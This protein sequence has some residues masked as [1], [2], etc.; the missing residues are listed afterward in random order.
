MPSVTTATHRRVPGRMAC[1]SVPASVR[2]LRDT[3]MGKPPRA[4]PLRFAILPPS[5][6]PLRTPI[7]AKT[8]PHPTCRAS[9]ARM[10]K[11]K[12]EEHTMPLFCR[13]AL[14]ALVLVSAPAIFA[15][16]PAPMTPD[17][18][19]HFTPP[20]TGYDYTIRKVM[21]PM[22]DGVKLFTIIAIPK[23][24]KD[25]PIVLTRTPYNAAA[26][27]QAE[28][29]PHMIDALPL[30]S[31]EFVKA[32]YIHVF[33]DVRGKYGSQGTYVMTPPPTGPLNPHGPNDTTDAWDTIDWLVKNLPESNGRVGMIGSSYEGFTVVMALLHPH[34]A[35]KVAAPESPMI[36]GWM[37]DDWFH[38]GAFREPNLDY[39]G[40]QT[41]DHGS[42][43]GLP[44][45]NY[46]D[47]TNFLEAGS[48]GAFAKYGGIQNLTF[49]RQLHDHPAYDAYWQEQALDKLIAKVPLKVPVLWEQ[50]LWDQ[51]DMWGANHSY[52]A[53]EPQDKNNNMNYLVMGPWFHSQI[54]RKGWSLGPLQWTGDTTLQY[55]KMVLAFFN[56]YLKDG[57]PKANIPPVWIYNTGENH[58]DS[59]NKWPLSCDHGCEY[60][61]KPLYLAAHGKLS[62]TSPLAAHDAAGEYSQ[63]VSDPA[64]PVPFSP[65]PYNGGESMAWRTWLVHD[66]RFVDGRPDV[67]TFET[68]PLTEPVRL[69]GRPIVH[70]IAS[71]SGTDSDWVVKLIDVYPGTYSYDP[72][73]GGYELPIATDIFRGRYR[74]SFAHPEPITP[75]KPL[76]YHFGL[77]MVNHVF[78]PGH[79]IMVQVQSTLFPLYDRNPQKYVANIFDAKPGDFQKATQRI[80]HTAG[81]ASFIDLPVAPLHISTAQGSQTTGQ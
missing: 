55:R 73:M 36:D 38:Y 37:G 5:S 79:R 21:I 10:L 44:R 39:I 2:W 50:G 46:D 65:R 16:A 61:S 30:G 49:Y 24:A 45:E 57:A 66:Q 26:R 60:Q 27:L 52:E 62:F 14:L 20:H 59:F 19:A 42:G 53:L 69:A 48:A 13:S 23:G 32:G 35:L 28:E 64:K 7:S 11:A 34:P 31:D 67:L 68:V 77:P 58:W 80:W 76:L 17:I 40:E 29:S 43:K 70:L 8:G 75:N 6:Q 54:N 18:P 78:E 33:Q 9:R 25:A 51:E 74:I 12:L 22:R 56:Q 72:P 4:A 15:Q 41:E 3:A 47:Y 63:Y 1:N 71:T 81:T